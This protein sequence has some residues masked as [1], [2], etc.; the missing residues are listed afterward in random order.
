[1]RPSL[2]AEDERVKAAGLTFVVQ[3]APEAGKT[4]LLTHLQYLWGNDPR[5]SPNFLPIPLPQLTNMAHAV[6]LITQKADSRKANKIF[7]SKSTTHNLGSSLLE[8]F[9]FNRT[10]IKEPPTVPETLIRL[11]EL[12]PPE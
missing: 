6:S 4:A 11:A 1:M 9:E 2:A 10:T 12:I 7:S 3:G 5:N 8:F